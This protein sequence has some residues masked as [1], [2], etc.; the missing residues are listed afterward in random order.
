M[1]NSANKEEEKVPLSYALLHAKCP[2]CRKGDMFKKSSY[3]SFK[4]QVMYENC[5]YCNLRYEKEPGYWYV[6]MFVSYALNVGE[7]L[8]VSIITYFVT[9]NL[10]NP[11][12]YL[13][14]I[15]PTIFIFAPFNYRY[16]RV[17]LLYWLTP[18][19]KYDERRSSNPHKHS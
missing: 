16:S 6:A 5:P 4:G 17:A 14:V 9:H 12:L 19:L 13:G 7:M 11:W 8:T 2:R 15:F 18:G 3:F 10:E 1:N